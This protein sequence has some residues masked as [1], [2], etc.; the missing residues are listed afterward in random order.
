MIEPAPNYWT[1]RIHRTGNNG[2]PVFAAQYMASTHVNSVEAD[3]A[4]AGQSHLR[5]FLETYT[6]IDPKEFSYK[7]QLQAQALLGGLV[8]TSDC[9]LRFGIW[10]P[11]APPEARALRNPKQP[12]PKAT[13]Q[14]NGVMLWLQETGDVSFQ[15]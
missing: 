14:E 1:Y 2:Q 7:H 15:G 9:T 3:L 10:L 6:R 12:I 11:V 5:R 13:A 8:A 4:E